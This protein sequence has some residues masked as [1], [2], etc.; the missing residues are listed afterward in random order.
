[1]T[2]AGHAHR[3]IHYLPVRSACTA[4]VGSDYRRSG[5]AKQ[6]RAMGRVLARRLPTPVEFLYTNR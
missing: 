4:A 3:S 5:D 6:T 1:V 2:T